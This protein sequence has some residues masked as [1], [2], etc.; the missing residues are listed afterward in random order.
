MNPTSK[1]GGQSVCRCNGSDVMSCARLFW[2]MKVTRPPTPIVTSDGANELFEVMT[3]VA[4]N[5]G[6]PGGA[7]V[8]AG[9]GVEGGGVEAAGGVGAV[10][11]DDAPPPVQA[12]ARHATASIATRRAR[13]PP[14][15]PAMPT[16]DPF[17][18]RSLRR[19]APSLPSVF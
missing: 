7:G 3:T 16:F 6:G 17:A 11:V 4:V 15:A 9:G 18:L 5:G 8:G 12:V 14:Y 2:L 10:G 13:H 19:L 1:I